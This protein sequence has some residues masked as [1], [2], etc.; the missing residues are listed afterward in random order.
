MFANLKKKIE[1]QSELGRGLSTA[2]QLSVHG[3]HQSGCSDSS[4]STSSASHSSATSGAL[5]D[6]HSSSG[7]KHVN[8][9][10]NEVRPNGSPKISSAKSGTKSSQVSMKS[11]W[12]ERELELH[13]ENQ[14][15]HKQLRDLVSTR[16]K[17][18]KNDENRSELEDFQ[19]QELAKVK[20]L[21][22]Q[23]QNELKLFK[24]Q[25]KEKESCLS[26][27]DDIIRELSEKLKEVNADNR[28]KSQSLLKLGK[29]VDIL[30]EKN[31]I[32]MHEIKEKDGRIISLGEI[33]S[34]FKQ[35]KIE[36]VASSDST[37]KGLMEQKELL[38]NEVDLLKRKNYETSALME[39][40]DNTIT[41]YEERIRIL[42][43][44]VNDSSLG[45]GEK[46]KIVVNERSE[47]EKK[48]EESRHHLS[49][50]KLSWSDKINNLENQI[51]HLNKKIAD[52][53]DEAAKLEDQYRAL[54]DQHN[55]LKSES[56]LLRTKLSDMETSC[57]NRD[58]LSTECENLECERDQLQKTCE[59]LEAKV[60]VLERQ[61]ANVEEMLK[62]EQSNSKRKID[63]LMAQN[64]EH[65]EKEIECESLISNQES[66]ISKLQAEIDSKSKECNSLKE[67]IRELNANQET[68]LQDVADLKQKLLECNTNLDGLQNEIS[69]TESELE[70]IQRERDV[71]L[72]RNSELSQQVEVTKKTVT[73][74]K[75]LRERL[76]SESDEKVA[77]L[78]KLSKD[79]KIQISNLEVAAGSSIE[80][81]ERVVELKNS[82]V[83]LESQLAEKNKIIKLQQHRLAD[84]KKT[85]QKELKMQHGSDN[86]T[87]V[88]DGLD[89]SILGLTKIN[90]SIVSSSQ[91]NKNISAVDKRS[92]GDQ[93]NIQYLRHVVFKFMTSKE[94]E[95]LQLIKAISVLLK[96][97]AEEEKIIKQ[98]LDWKM[99]WFGHKP[100]MRSYVSHS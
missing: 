61:L 79:L 21:L 65:L 32:L 25:L 98:T 78:E 92:C 19:K 69:S 28:T 9:H 4:L 14:S 58:E 26:K 52:D 29:D 82:V 7:H 86:N 45:N 40:K 66:I 42:E 74:E 39:D 2:A 34:Q 41:H 46:L 48:L 91:S 60:Q 83:E 49:E 96:F 50:I 68:A 56:D 33:E 85:L 38:S 99:S 30:N 16:E 22:L 97:S 47:L 64:S 20:H 63:E 18:I 90:K 51:S 72:L 70:T 57:T 17:L 75:A 100:E 81:L 62:I 95:A 55:A 35:L 23:C 77:E 54:C 59:A 5:P 37:L 87:C 43:K 44:R 88:G 94:Y 11:Q 53:S 15:L 71:L 12:S 67:N 27:S 89:I 10:V 93:I 31:D 76:Q 1:E 73:E 6:L 36:R 13:R 84:M 80:N 8:N 3:F 24:D